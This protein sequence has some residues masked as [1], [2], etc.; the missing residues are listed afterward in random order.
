MAGL[1]QQRLGDFLALTFGLP[2]I[3]KELDGSC[4]RFGFDI[5]HWPEAKC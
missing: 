2:V 4:V 1:D 5:A 3:G